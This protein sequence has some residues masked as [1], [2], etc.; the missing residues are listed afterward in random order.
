MAEGT[1]PARVPAPAIDK[2]E[3]VAR[4]GYI[5]ARLREKSTYAGLTVVV[6]LLLPL[7]ARYV[8][9][10]AHASAAAIVEDISMIGIGLGGLI[11]IASPEGRKTLVLLA[12][13][14]SLILAGGGTA[15]AAQK[16]APA[17]AA[18][19]P[20]PT[21]AGA[22][23]TLIDQIHKRDAAII[24]NI[25]AAIE[26]ADDDAGTIV[27]PASGSTPAVFKDPIA[28]ACYPAQIQWLE[29]LPTL[30][31]TKIQPPYDVIVLFQ[32][33][34]DLINMLLKGQLIPDYLKLGCS[35]LL[36]SEA[37]IFAAT[38]GLVGVGAAVTNP[39]TAL[40]TSLGAAAITTMPLLKL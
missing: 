27:T 35:A 17:K 25:I 13:G 4:V 28:H 6:S 24:K 39:I 30:Q 37:Q 40:G 38:L 34:R 8:P 19:A 2:A 20:A 1:K 26:A 3:L 33:K 9:A 7:L 21:L 22:I 16:A 36:G 15:D 32:F 29:S 18:P 12:I 11:A 5:G 23:E 14:V 31:S 10:L